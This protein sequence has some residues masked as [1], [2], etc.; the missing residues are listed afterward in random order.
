MEE[1][2]ERLAET[3]PDLQK[4]IS[5]HPFFAAYGNASEDF[6]SLAMLCQE[7]AAHEDA[8]MEILIEN[9]HTAEILLTAPCFVF[10]SR[11]FLLLQK[12][13]FVANEMVFD[14]TE[15][16]QSQI[17]VTFDFSKADEILY[18]QFQKRIFK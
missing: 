12:I 10:E 2:K 17:T 8:E 14:A 18:R 11:Q 7:L 13:S 3:K 15:E 6:L 5:A 16:K 4:A 9:D 1:A